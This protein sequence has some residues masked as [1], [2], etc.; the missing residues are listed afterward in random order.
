MDRAYARWMRCALVGVGVALAVAL[1][2]GRAEAAVQP[3][4]GEIMYPA[5]PFCPEGWLPADGRLVRITFYHA[6]FSLI[7]TTYGGD[8]EHTFGLPDLPPLRSGHDAAA[9]LRPCIAYHGVFP[10]RH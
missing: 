6:L 10:R 9:K 4:I 1:G 7:G 2:A 8:G 5:F 3:F